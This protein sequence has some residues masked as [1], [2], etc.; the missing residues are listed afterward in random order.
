MIGKSVP[1]ERILHKYDSYEI[2]LGEEPKF[3][4]K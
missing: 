2:V 3:K 4:E 1:C